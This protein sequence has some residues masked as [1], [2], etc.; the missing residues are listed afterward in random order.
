VIEKPIGHDLA[1]AR[2]Q[3]D[4]GRVLP[5]RA[6]KDWPAAPRGRD[7]CADGWLR[8][9]PGAGSRNPRRASDG[10]ARGAR[11]EPE[12]RRGGAVL[13]PSRT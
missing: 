3:R 12:P 5:R 13:Q 9:A 6:G 10:P 2:D 11:T 7:R 8:R 1:S 4:A